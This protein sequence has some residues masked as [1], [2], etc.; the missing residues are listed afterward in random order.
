MKKEQCPICYSNLEVKEFAPCDDCGGLEEEINHFKNGIHKYTVYE[1]YDGL[2]LQ[3]CNFCDVDFG[4]YKSEYLGLL[5]N[6]RI[7]YENFKFISSVQNPSIQKTKYC[8]ECNKGIKFLTFLRDLR[9]KEK[10]G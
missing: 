3:L 7:G 9:A 8:P 2:E 1:I 6:R 10:K 4:S 5:G